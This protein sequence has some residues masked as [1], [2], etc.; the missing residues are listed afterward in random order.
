MTNVERTSGSTLLVQMQWAIPA[1]AEHKSHDACLN[2]V[3][4][5]LKVWM[6]SLVGLAE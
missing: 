5:P 3:H 6:S 1:M 4:M 2:E